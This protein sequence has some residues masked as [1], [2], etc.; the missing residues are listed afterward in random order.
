M[1]NPSSTYLL[2]V[3]NELPK[4]LTT[5]LM[6]VS[7]SQIGFSFHLRKLFSILNI[8]HFSYTTYHCHF[9]KSKLEMHQ[10]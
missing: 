3:I 10:A 2:T 8:R 5:I 6:T 4:D 9:A 1:M 7:L